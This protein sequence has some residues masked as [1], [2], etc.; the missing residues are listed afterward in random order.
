MQQIQPEGVI[1]N[2]VSEGVINL[3]SSTPRTFAD[4]PKAMKMNGL[5]G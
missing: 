1:N 2:P 5:L 4:T 3:S